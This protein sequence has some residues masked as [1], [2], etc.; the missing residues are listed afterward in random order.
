M[1]SEH[2]ATYGEKACNSFNGN[3]HIDD[4]FCHKSTIAALCQGRLL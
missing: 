4:S 3:C 1:K 2:I